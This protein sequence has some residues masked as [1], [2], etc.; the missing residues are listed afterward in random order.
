MTDV[1]R[2]AGFKGEAL[3]IARA[4]AQAESGLNPRAY[5]PNAGTGDK[6]YGLFQI[7]MLGAMGPARRAQYGLKSNEDL[8]DPLTNAK[9]AFRM[10]GGG[11]NWSPWSTYKSGVYKK[12]LGS[13]IAEIPN[14]TGPAPVRKLPFSLGDG[15]DDNPFAGIGKAGPNPFDAV[16]KMR[17]G[18]PFQELMADSPFAAPSRPA[19]SPLPDMVPEKPGKPLAW[20]G[21]IQ[22]R[23]GPSAPHTRATLE[24]V[25][26]VAATYGKVLTPWGNESHSLTTVNGNVSDHGSGRAAD[27]PATGAELV[28]IGRAALVAAGAD[29]RWAAKQTGGLFN[30]GSHQVIFNTDKGGN[31]YDHVH[32]SV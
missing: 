29:P 31:H 24:F 32:V 14:A 30:I 15:L 23:Q 16:K 13:D 4:I 21:K 2:Q 3:K 20:V 19:Q 6:S 28:R 10:S 1:L 27:I 17:S 12:H 25:G 18:N 22:H 11:T 26:K 9:V 5:N 7:N 8:F